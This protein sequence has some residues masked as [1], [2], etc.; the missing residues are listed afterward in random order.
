MSLSWKEIFPLGACRLAREIASGRL[1]ARDAVLAHVGRIEE[2]NP[3]LNAVVFRRFDEALAEAAAADERQAR[4]EALG[5]LHGV[6]VSV[7]DSIFVAGTPSTGGLPSR[8]A[9]RAEADSPLVARLRRAGAIVLGKTNVPQMLLYIESD[10]PLFGRAN[11]PWSLDRSP[12]G[13][14]GGEGALVAASG[15]TLGLG[16][17]LG[18]SIRIPAHV[19]GIHGLKP[20]SL[21]LPLTG[22]LEA[23]FA[24]GQEAM[25]PAPGPLARHVR[26]LALAMELLTAPG[27]ETDTTLPPVPKPVPA[28]TSLAGLRVGFYTD[29]GW[30]PPSPACA[31]AV[32]EAAEALS[33]RGARVEEFTPPD[34]PE[35]MRIF[36]GLPASAGG[37]WVK[38]FV[39]GG[40]VDP[41]LA[42]LLFAATL[43]HGAARLLASALEIAGQHRRARVVRALGRRSA[44]RYSRLVADRAAYRDRFLA[45]DGAGRFDIWLCPPSPTPALTHGASRHLLGAASYTM[46]WNL[47]GWPA[48]VVAATR[49]RSEEEEGRPESR[50]PVDRAARRVDAGSAGLPVG[51]QVAAR[52]WREDL[53]L[54]AMAAL[55]EDFRARSDYPAAP[56]L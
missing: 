43:P 3:R 50:D 2:V 23:L 16:T 30:F 17:D 27:E 39:A 9:H 37:G 6:P 41:R 25:V 18:G 54:A 36:F 32:R 19:N 52:P 45:P 38:R 31:R 48:G 28:A 10:N 5:P 49:V 4:G 44:E 42:E 11:N 40:P 51:V 21:R 29:D 7:K 22:T 53:V 47:L 14:S 15:S 34:V 20:T 55:E 33:G 26:D 56:P 24:P 12:G 35:A 46:L 8:A 1:S 13:S